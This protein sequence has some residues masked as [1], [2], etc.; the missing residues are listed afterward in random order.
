MEPS[1]DFLNLLNSE[2]SKVDEASPSEAP[3]AVQAK[4]VRTPEKQRGEKI[5]KVLKRRGTLNVKKDLL[6]SCIRDE[7][8]DIDCYYHTLADIEFDPKEV[9]Y[10]MLIPLFWSLP[11]NDKQPFLLE[12]FNLDQDKFSQYWYSYPEEPSAASVEKEKAAQGTSYKDPFPELTKLQEEKTTYKDYKYDDPAVGRLLKSLHDTSLKYAKIQDDI[13]VIRE[14]FQ[15][16]K[17]EVLAEKKKLDDA[18]DDIYMKEQKAADHIKNQGISKVDKVKEDTISNATKD[19]NEKEIAANKEEIKETERLTKEAE[20]QTKEIDDEEKKDNE[21]LERHKQ[22]AIYV[23]D[24]GKHDIEAATADRDKKATIVNEIQKIFNDQ[25]IENTIKKLDPSGKTDGGIVLADQIEGIRILLDD[26][27][28]PPNPTWI[29]NDN[30]INITSDEYTDVLNQSFKFITNST[31]SAV[32]DKDPV[33]LN[34]RGKKGSNRRKIYQLI[35]SYGDDSQ[36]KSQLAWATA[37]FLWK[38]INNGIVKYRNDIMA[39]HKIA[40][41][42]VTEIENGLREVEIKFKQ[43]ANKGYPVRRKTIADETKEAIRALKEATTAEVERLAQ[44]LQKV[45]EA[46][47]A[48]NTASKIPI[49]DTYAAALA[50]AAQKR[51]SAKAAANINAEKNIETLKN[52]YDNDVKEPNEKLLVLN[53]TIEKLISELNKIDIDLDAKVRAKTWVDRE[54]EALRKVKNPVKGGK[55][56]HD[57]TIRRRKN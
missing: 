53:T 22:Y 8:F 57:K 44:E 43:K 2:W 56:R 10:R 3:A 5:A 55:R 21:D 19:K 25:Q 36:K 52:S 27:S 24:E 54:V 39:A 38:K 18:T 35:L 34:I 40:E 13:N 45:I 49:N 33:I 9:D 51:D 17:D 42:K 23:V 4:S 31:N 46:A 15:K 28:T 20:K 12:L 7:R 16:D 14:Q 26:G 30:W 32:W 1:I 37:E 29:N 41:D 11:V 48:T 6:E 50:T 47:Q